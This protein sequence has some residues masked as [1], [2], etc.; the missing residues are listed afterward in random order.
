MEAATSGRLYGEFAELLKADADNVEAVH[1]MGCWHL[2]QGSMHVAR[3]HFDR[4]ASLRPNS[5]D[6]RLCVSV[7]SALSGEL[8]AAAKAV[9]HAA[10]LLE[11]ADGDVR[12]LFCQAL[13]EEKKTNVRLALKAYRACA[14]KCTELLATSNSSSSTSNSSSSSSSSSAF[15]RAAAQAPFLAD[16]KAEAQLRIA[17]VQKEMGA[18]D[19]ATRTCQTILQEAPGS[20]VRA[21]ALCV[22]GIVCEI[23][24]NY[25]QAEAVYRAAL[26]QVEHHAVALERLGRLYLR[27]RETVPAA[28]KCLFAAV[29]ANPSNHVA[30]Y[31]LGRCYMVVGQYGDAHTAYGKSLNIFPN[32]PQVWCSLGVLFY[33][34]GQYQDALG[35]LQHALAL[36]PSMAD[37]WYNVG[38]LYQMSDQ[39]QHAD[40]AYAR[41][42]D[43]GLD[44]RLA[45]AGMA[46]AP[47]TGAAVGAPATATGAAAMYAAHAGGDGATAATGGGNGGRQHPAY[48]GSHGQAFAQSAH[49]SHPEGG[50]DD[51]GDED[52]DDDEEDDEEEE[53]DDGE[54]EGEEEEEDEEDEDGA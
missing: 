52:D 18:L 35:A 6:V 4:L 27:Y 50:E 1:F 39:Q 11:G 34:H 40:L 20:T 30:W 19:E 28:V 21:N 42:K 16:I 49:T 51:D 5:P 43:C 31:L 37:A 26:Q 2:S 45:Q 38:A 29:E 22:Q 33:A 14:D 12:V 17:L 47:P 7:C 48:V 8:D 9:K 15:S 23:R 13:V 53:D 54:E 24:Q 41:A 25:P 36:D 32:D 44:R 10:A 3:Q 46:A